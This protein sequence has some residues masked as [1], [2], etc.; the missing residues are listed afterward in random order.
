MN[1]YA[2]VYP[3]E[4]SMHDLCM[5]RK[6]DTPIGVISVEDDRQFWMK[7]DG[8]WQG[9]GPPSIMNK[10]DP[11][12]Y[13]EIITRAEFE[14]DLAFG[15]WPEL[16]TTHRPVRQWY[17]RSKQQLFEVNN[18]LAV[19]SFCVFGMIATDSDVPDWVKV[20]LALHGCMTVAYYLVGSFFGGYDAVRKLEERYN[21]R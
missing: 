9:D 5:V 13:Y 2:R 15:L 17:R 12:F 18:W 16:K 7:I 6:D 1:T 10:R 3:A 11:G 20:A 19:F 4:Y 8:K 14:S 21:G